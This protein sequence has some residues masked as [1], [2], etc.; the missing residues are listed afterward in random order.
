MNFNNVSKK[1]WITVGIIAAFILMIVAMSIS[2]KNQVISL[3]EQINESKSAIEVQEMARISKVDNLVATVKEYSKY[4]A[5]TLKDVIATRGQ[6]TSGGAGIENAQVAISAV[7]EQYPDLKANENYKTLM[8][9]LISIENKI[10][11]YRDNY[12]IQ[13]KSY[14]KAC[15]TFPNSALLSIMGYEKLDYAYA[16]FGAPEAAPRN[17]FE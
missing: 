10:A 7:A 14:N 13:V 12:N 9:E 1:T 17:I 5:E 4:E 15:R 16:E 8:L 2:A 3:E 11:D 6:N